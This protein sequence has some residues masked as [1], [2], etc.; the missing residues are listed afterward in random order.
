MIPQLLMHLNDAACS[1]PAL[2]LFQLSKSVLHPDALARLCE[3]ANPVTHEISRGSALVST[4]VAM[5]IPEGYYGRIAPRSGL[6][7]KSALHVGAGVVDPD[8]RVCTTGGMM[9]RNVTHCGRCCTSKLEA[10]AAHSRVFG[11]GR[12]WPTL[13][14]IAT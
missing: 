2:C 1:R 13:G 11:F 6:A 5:A 3:C 4:G 14:A 7:V 12:M 8:Y 10:A 9:R